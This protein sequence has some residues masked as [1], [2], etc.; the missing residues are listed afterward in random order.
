MSIKNKSMGDSPNVPHRQ[1]V[2]AQHNTFKGFTHDH[3][4]T[5]SMGQMVPILLLET[6]PGDHFRIR[7]EYMFRFA[8]LYLPIMHKVD[9][10]IDYYFCPNRI[11]TANILTVEP[12]GFRNIWEQ[13]IQDF[14]GTATV[15]IPRYNLV[16]DDFKGTEF[17]SW[18]F[19]YMGIPTDDEDNTSQ[20]LAERELIA[21]PFFVYL[22][23][24]EEYHRNIQVQIQ[25]FVPYYVGMD[26]NTYLEEALND[27]FDGIDKPMSLLHRN[28]PRDYY[29]SML[30]APQLGANVIIPIFNNDA[31]FP[32]G[33]Q[34]IFVAS[35]GTQGFD[36]GL[37]GEL[38]GGETW[39]TT[40]GGIPVVIDMSSTAG[41]M[42]QL[43][44]NVKLQ[45]FM[46]RALR[47]GAG[48]TR[49]SSFIQGY[50][51][52]DPFPGLI[53]RPVWFGGHVGRVV[54]SDVLSTAETTTANIGAYAGQALAADNTNT[55]KYSCYEH[56]WI[57]G[58]CSVVPRASYMNGIARMWVRQTALDY[59]WEQFA[60]IGDQEVYG[61]EIQEGTHG[62]PFLLNDRVFAYT[63]RYQEMR[64]MNDIASG[65]MRSVFL[66]FHLG[67]NF[68][69][70][71]AS[72]NVVQL[73]TEFLE[74]R[75]DVGRCFII[76]AEAGEHEVYAQI[77]HYIEVDRR[78]P[79]NAIPM[80]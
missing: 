80:L 6:M 72:E 38:N 31:P 9:V 26:V 50:F 22:Y 71:G 30:P 54:V 15:D 44:Y 64:Y 2:H 1:E 56:G 74:C 19:S 32:W 55:Y 53:D 67:R 20:P 16:H 10:Y 7:G 33:P 59:P 8:P 62:S 39:L 51:D 78:L 73:N 36:A 3:K 69:Q 68:P 70:G 13:F 61:Y 57:M 63:P 65:Q 42:A 48:S 14:D 75:P 11:L 21:F 4:T 5:F 35:D 25:K 28:W 77:A 76:D 43:R 17:N 60:L 23:I 79:R 24:W 18:I 47:V 34:Q 12:V 52:V 66:S 37:K 41:T 46:E 45:E 29:T 58:I 40:D 27:D 49:Y